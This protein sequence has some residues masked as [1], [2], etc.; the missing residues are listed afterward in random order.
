MDAFEASKPDR[1]HHSLSS[2]W[3]SFLGAQ[4]CSYEVNALRKA[5]E[6]HIEQTKLSISSLQSDSVARHDLL[7]TA[8]AESKSTIEQHTAELKEAAAFR[9]SLS[10]FQK[11]ISDDRKDASMKV[12]EL[13]KQVQT[14]QEGLDALRSSTS[15]NT[16]TVQEQCRL[17]LEKVDSLQ[18]ELREAK[19]ERR[20]SE[21]KLAALESQIKTMTWTQPRDELPEDSVKLLGAI[22]SRRDELMTLL[23]TQHIAIG[24][25]CPPEPHSQMGVSLPEAPLVH[26]GPSY[27]PLPTPGTHGVEHNSLRPDNPPVP[28]KRPLDESPQPYPKRPAP[29]PSTNPSQDIR[30]LY[31]V[32]RD[33]YKT[34]PPKSDTAFIWEFLSRI[35]DPA[36]SKHIQDSLAAIIPEHV[37]PTRDTR[38]RNPRRHVDIS[39]GLTWRKFREALVRIPG[40]P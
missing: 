11:E 25:Q 8:V 13:S 21:Q 20:S 32:F 23:K 7:S 19:E 6:E 28:T 29:G 2:A 12:A 15:Q 18:A 17:A 27:K 9:N 22:L 30:T 38:R 37:T 24:S 10:T 26:E 35:E 34:D 31:L 3:A 5:L 14:H 4:H 40:P 39:K 16:R 36:M 33:R 1:F